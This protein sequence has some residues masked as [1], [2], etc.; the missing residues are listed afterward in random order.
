MHLFSSIASLKS[1]KSIL[2]SQLTSCR[3]QVAALQRELELHQQLLSDANVSGSS[4]A[5]WG[6]GS[7]L[8]V[9]TL[10]EEIK[11]L[12]RQLEASLRNNVILADSLKVRLF[13]LIVSILN[14]F[15]ATV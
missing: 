1:E 3:D 8:S 13:Y 15:R 4:A 9:D 12:R 11:A 10:L 5:N 2:L 7:S 6:A 14:P